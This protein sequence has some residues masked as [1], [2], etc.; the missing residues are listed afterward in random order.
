MKRLVWL[1]ALVLMSNFALAA[2]YAREKKWADEVVPGVVA[3]DPVYLE[4]PDGHK[5]LTLY[6]PAKDARAALIIVHG[7]GVNPDWGLIG[8]LRSQLPDRGYTTLSIQ[9]PVLASNAKAT[10]YPA[11]FPE[12]VQRLNIAVDF[13]KAKGYTKIGLVSHSMGSRMSAVYMTGKPDAAVKAWVAI[14]MADR[15]DYRKVGVPVLDLYGENDLPDVLKNARA[16]KT[17]LQGKTGS[18]QEM[19]AHADHF[20]DNMDE[21]LVNIVSKYLD[22]QF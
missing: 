7:M 17:A 5:F 21:Q 18:K 3:G 13:L 20:F 11:T 15:V 14:G 12:A 1:M 10:A 19:V 8:V 22:Q 9:M 6:T 4:Q 16:R 2:D